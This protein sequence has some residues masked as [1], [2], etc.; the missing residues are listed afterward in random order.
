MCPP[1]VLVA[2]WAVAGAVSVAI[3]L[4][5]VQMQHPFMLADV[6][7]DLAT[8]L[9]LLD[10]PFGRDRIAFL[11]VEIAGQAHS[12]TVRPTLSSRTV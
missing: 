11:G 5:P 2:Q 3:A 1:L 8:A 10:Q 12:P 6:P 4:V 9:S 7:A